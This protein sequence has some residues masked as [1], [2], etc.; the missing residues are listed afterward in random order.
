LYPFLG[1]PTTHTTIVVL[2]EKGDSK[3]ILEEFQSKLKFFVRTLA[4]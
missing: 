4:P 3:I 2:M 1:N